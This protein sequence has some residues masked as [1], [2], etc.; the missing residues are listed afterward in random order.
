MARMIP[1]YISPEVKSTGEKQIFELFKNDPV[2]E[3][4]I[5]LHSLNLSQHTRR[6]YGEIDFLV[7]APG[8]GIFVLEVKSGEVKRKEG[9][10][11]FVNRF[12]EINTSPKGPFVQA[13]E[14]MF[15]ILESIKAN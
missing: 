1:P 13:Q 15:S 5:V 7:L 9:V 4:W 2:T 10:W 11:Q 14:G 6:L 12:K 3:S 8:L